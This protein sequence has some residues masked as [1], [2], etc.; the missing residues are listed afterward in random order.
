M[1]E[2]GRRSFAVSLWLAAAGCRPDSP[3]FFE[4][5]GDMVNA[6]SA[7]GSSSSGSS[8]SSGGG[9]SSGSSTGSGPGSSS[10]GE[11]SV[12]AGTSS[13]TG[14][15]LLD[16]G[17]ESEGHFGPPTWCEARKVDVLISM[18]HFVSVEPY[19]DRARAGFQALMKTLEKALP[20]VDLHVMMLDPDGYWG[21][22]PCG[23]ES[24]AE[25][26]GCDLIDEPQYPCWAYEPGYLSACDLT[27]GA[28]VT[29]PAGR[30]AANYRC[31]L[32][33]GRRYITSAQANLG[34]ALD[35]VS[36]LGTSGAGAVTMDAVRA[37]LSPEMLGPGGC[38]YGFVRDDALLLLV[39]VSPYGDYG[40]EYNP[41]VW[42]M[43]LAKVKDD[44]DSMITLAMSLPYGKKAPF[45]DPP[46]YFPPCCFDEL[47]GYVPHGV[48]GDLCAASY[49]PYFDAVAAEMASICGVPTPE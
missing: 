49:Q 33:G 6:G 37:A 20:G 25:T 43:Q 41:Y 2:I 29:F 28:G 39:L 22:P 18:V 34:V 4:G 30:G 32:T 11:A 1:R 8:S 9:S 15:L 16:L 42:S 27:L 14:E 7:A 5:A 47:V 21:V 36:D 46:E 38:N 40:S 23:T 13:G 24:C 17:A 44:P 19:Y 35:C 31:G 12:G 26:L 10:T 3:G 45:C 48:L